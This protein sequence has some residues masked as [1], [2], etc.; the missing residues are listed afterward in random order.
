[1][2]VTDDEECLGVITP[3]ELLQS[4]MDDDTEAEAVMKFVPKLQRNADVR[5]TARLLIENER[6]PRQSTRAKRCGAAST[7]MKSSKLRDTYRVK[8]G[9]VIEGEGRFRPRLERLVTVDGANNE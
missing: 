2:L 5:E 4:H 6:W 8:P 9:E 7:L 1:M 3:Q